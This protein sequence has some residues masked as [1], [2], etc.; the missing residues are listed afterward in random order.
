M[1]CEYYNLEL[2]NPT[3]S[4]DSIDSIDTK[5]W[6]KNAWIFLN[7]IALTYDN[8]N[9]DEYVKFLNQL[10]YVLPCL[11][12]REHFKN[13]LLSLTDN[14][15]E[16]K[17]TFLNWLLKVRN[18]IYIEQHRPL[19]TKNESIAEIFNKGYNN[20]YNI[21]FLSI[22]VIIIIFIYLKN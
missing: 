2:I 13:N 5:F 22:S 8:K 14:D 10:Q 11:K 7:S 9:K 20:Y 17:E 1:L 6:G 15:M 12:C 16:N 21:I 4:I 18:S 19:K 3:D